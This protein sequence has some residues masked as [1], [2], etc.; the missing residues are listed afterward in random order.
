MEVGGEVGCVSSRE[1]VQSRGVFWRTAVFL[2]GLVAASRVVFW[3]E[4]V[5][6][7]GSLCLGMSLFVSA[8]G[9]VCLLL[10]SLR[11][12]GRARARWKAGVVTLVCLPAYASW[13][14]LAGSPATRGLIVSTVGL[15]PEIAL[16]YL[17]VTEREA[18]LAAIGETCA[19]ARTA[20]MGVLER[21]AWLS[22]L[23]LLWAG[24]VLAAVGGVMGV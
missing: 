11:P 17:W 7:P 18:M 21:I 13:V 24:Y 19:E 3:G 8:M 9:A 12:R 4:A 5:A 1:V 22:P 23:A 14:A 15:L 16:S 6:K 20:A 10:L 2:G